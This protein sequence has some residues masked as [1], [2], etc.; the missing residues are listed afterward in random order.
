VLLLYC[1]DEIS[2]P[3][4]LTPCGHKGE[5]VWVRQDG[6]ATLARHCK[7]LTKKP[8]LDF[9]LDSL[10]LA[11]GLDLVQIEGDMDAT[12]VNLGPSQ[13]WWHQVPLRQVRAVHITGLGPLMHEM[14]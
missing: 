3:L 14:M 7:H 2:G 4:A 6:Q 9:R 8:D 11:D 10:V 5:D 12:N 1:L 13:Q